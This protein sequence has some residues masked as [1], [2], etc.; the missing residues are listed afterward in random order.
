M[1]HGATRNGLCG[2]PQRDTWTLPLRRARIP[3]VERL[4]GARWMATHQRFEHEPKE[5]TEVPYDRS[6][7]TEAEDEGFGTPE[8]HNQ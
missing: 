1:P 2:T 8:R 4:T 6:R 5:N 7:W 3:R